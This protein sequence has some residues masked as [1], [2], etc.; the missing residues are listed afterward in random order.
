MFPNLSFYV[1]RTNEN[2]EDSREHNTELRENIKKLENE[3]SKYEKQLE[4]AM[5]EQE[6]LISSLTLTNGLK[7]ILEVDLQRTT[8]ELKAREEDCNYLQKQLKMLT[9]NKKQ[10]QRDAELE[11]LKELRKEINIAREV[12]IQLEA[13]INRAKQELKESSNREL[14]FV[15]TVDSLKEREKGLNTRL[16]FSEEKERKLKDLIENANALGND[17]SVN[18]MQKIKELSDTVEKYAIEKSHFEDKIGKL[19]M[20]RKLLTQRV[21][22]LEE[23]LKKVK[24]TQASSHQT[25]SIE[26]V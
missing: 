26:R 16:A 3:M 8:A 7:E 4:I 17:V 21:K 6:R 11:E 25:V 22:L 24:S 23:Q 20:D 14:K 13:D 9:E 2:L 18:F 5:E 1:F 15:R 19:K 10:D 12:R